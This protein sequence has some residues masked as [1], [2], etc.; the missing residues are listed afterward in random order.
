MD[1]PQKHPLPP[2]T[3][4]MLSV[5]GVA[6]W[7]PVQPAPSLGKGVVESHSFLVVS[8]SHP[9]EYHKVKCGADVSTVLKYSCPGFKFLNVCSHAVTFT[10]KVFWQDSSMSEEQ[11]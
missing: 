1:K 6:R 10:V 9:E 8:E 5:L 7:S 4:S 11:P 3:T 2:K